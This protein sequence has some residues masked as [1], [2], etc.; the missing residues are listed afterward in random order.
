VSDLEGFA[1]LQASCPPGTSLVGPVGPSGTG[2]TVNDRL[3]AACM[4][5]DGTRHGPSV[6]WYA[7]GSKA[8]AGD[9]QDGL[10]EGEWLFWHEN[11]QMSGRGSF[12]QGKPHGTWTTWHDNGQKE[13]EG[14]YTDGLHHGRFEHWDRNGE[15]VQV[16]EYDNGNL[17]QRTLYKDGSP[18]G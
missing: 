11:G 5:P 17:I 8:L 10:Q 13:S 18:G 9:Y 2:R 1:D 3:T 6:T 12:Q 7:N 4:R 16:L 14:S 15:V